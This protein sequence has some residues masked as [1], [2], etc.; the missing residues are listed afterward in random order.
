MNISYIGIGAILFLILVIIAVLI[1]ISCV[2]IVHQAQAVVVERLGA[3]LTTWNTG[4][5]F[6]LP[7]I[8]RVARRID[9]KEQVVDFPPQPVITKDNVT[10]QI[11]TVVF[12]SVTDP[13][14]FCYGVASPIIAIENLTAT[15]LR[16]IIGDLELD[17]TLTSR[18]TINTKM[19][20]ELGRPQM[21]GELR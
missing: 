18:E 11:D 5:H 2:K 13:K 19:R 9:L 7:V 10:M 8:D 16:N 12:Y 21:P 4:L 17:Q 15:T 1:L 14:M 3:Y 20:A 6:K